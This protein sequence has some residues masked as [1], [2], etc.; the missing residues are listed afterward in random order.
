MNYYADDTKLVNRIHGKIISDLKNGDVYDIEICV[1]MSL[2]LAEYL[3]KETL[4]KEN[5][6]LPYKLSRL[7]TE[8]KN[9]AYLIKMGPEDSPD[10]HYDDLGVLLLRAEELSALPKTAL[11]LITSLKD[12]RNKVVRDPRHK[13]D[14]LVSHID[15]IDLF[16]KHA[17]IFKAVLG[18]ELRD[19]DRISLEEK[20]TKL[21]LVHSNRLDQKIEHH[22]NEYKRLTKDERESLKGTTVSFGGD[23]FL[24]TPE[25]MRC[26]S[27]YNLSL[28]Y[29]GSVD[30]DYD[31]VTGS[32]WLQCGVC[33]LEMDDYDFDE[34]V[35]NVR[36]YT[37]LSEEDESWSIYYDHKDWQA[38]IYEYI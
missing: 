3:V 5:E 32:E 12:G 26:P 13:I 19:K 22:R 9:M 28:H 24:V 37:S 23:V 8:H 38:N 17:D 15:L 18:I 1:V 4:R 6:L 36:K 21:K 35:T 25:L 30:V 34:L 16:V 33:D 2:I 27:C 11:Q 14:Q 29:M 10:A 20:L 7:Q 31:G